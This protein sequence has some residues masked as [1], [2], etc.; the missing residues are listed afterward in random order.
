MFLRGFDKEIRYFVKEEMMK[1][2]VNLIFNDNINSIKKISEPLHDLQYHISLESGKMAETGLVLY[3]TGR[4]PHTQDL[5]LANVD[6]QLNTRGEI[7][8]NE[9]FQT[10]EKSIYALGDVTGGMQ[11]TPVALAEGMYLANYFY[12]G[13]KPA[14]LD[15]SNI[16]AAVF[17]QPTIATVGLSEEQAKAEYPEVSVFVSN[18]K[19]MKHTLSGSDERC[20]MKMIV[21]N[22]TDKVL[23]VHMVGAEAGEIIQGM[24]VALKA[25]ATKAVFD[26]TIGIH[27]TAA[28]EFVTMRQARFN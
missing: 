10:S 23:G 6:I 19:P 14:L 12:S 24:A 8:V 27:P 11:L 2:G 1:K 9:Y 15:Y 3:A 17:C 18:F 21:D 28:E 16:P 4:T 20:L 13:Q 5:G 26:A 22:Q 25:G 7:Q